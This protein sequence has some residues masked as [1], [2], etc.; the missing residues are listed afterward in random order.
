M[1]SKTAKI[2][3]AIADRVECVSRR[4]IY[5]CQS[6]RCLPKS[7]RRHFERAI[8]RLYFHHRQKRDRTTLLR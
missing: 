2:Q 5:Q 3:Y 8:A 4:A 1:K 6:V 7:D